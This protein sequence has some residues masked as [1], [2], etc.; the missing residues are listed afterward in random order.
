MASRSG[1][2]VNPSTPI[3]PSMNPMNP[4]NPGHSSA[5][6]MPAMP[7]NSPYRGMG[8]TP[9]QYH[10][11]SEETTLYL[12]SEAFSITPQLPSCLDR[13]SVISLA[14][15]TIYQH[16]YVIKYCQKI[17]YKNASLQKYKQK[18]FKITLRALRP[19]KNKHVLPHLSPT[20][21]KTRVLYFE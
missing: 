4:M 10:Q 5:L 16:I 8:S 2:P 14:T 19:T 3:N 13:G 7:Q 17:I 1:F 11:V 18:M 6:R 9:N 20:M 21:K 12:L 15:I